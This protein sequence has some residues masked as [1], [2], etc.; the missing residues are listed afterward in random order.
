MRKHRLGKT[1]RRLLT[2]FLALYVLAAVAPYA[3]VPAGPKAEA[4]SAIVERQPAQGDR[5][6]ILPTGQQALE[7]RLNLIAN[8]KTSL[9][10]GTYLYA[11]DESGMT[12]ASALLAAADRGVSVRILTDG[13]IDKV[14]SV[15]ENRVDD[16]DSEELDATLDRMEYILQCW[17][18]WNPRKWEPAKN[19]DWSYADPVPLMYSS[20][21]HPN[22]AWGSRGIETPT[23][24][25][26]VDASCEAEVLTNRYVPKE[27]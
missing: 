2:A 15:I 21:S 16:I 19:P 8:A 11:D 17:E 5:A 14:R 9:V 18:D 10:V 24:M 6:A 25:R 13:L 3:A 27:G 1:L 26:S 4:V 22:E 7:T 20:G 23:S 12:I